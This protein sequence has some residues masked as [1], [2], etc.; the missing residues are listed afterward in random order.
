MANTNKQ[1]EQMAKNLM[2]GMTMMKKRMDTSNEEYFA[3]LKALGFEFS[4]ERLIRD[5]DRVRDTKTLEESYYQEC[6]QYLDRQD[7]DKVLNSDV[8][9]T[10]LMRIIPEHFAIEETGDP[11]FIESAIDD[12]CRKDPKKTDQ[13][14]IEKVLKALTVFSKTRDHHTLEGSLER[15]NINGLFNDL[16]RLCHNRNTEFRNLIREMYECFDDMDPKILPSVY[17][18]V[19][20]NKKQ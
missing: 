5:Y 11:F 10:L 16:I 1:F 2:A 14:E 15:F 18:E 20:K 7:Q 9:M 19:Q 12:L 4:E 8:F 17:K 6:G 13:K 3:K